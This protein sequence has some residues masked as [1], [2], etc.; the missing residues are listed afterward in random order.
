MLNA[1]AHAGG[2]YRGSWLLGRLPRWFW[3]VHEVAGGAFAAGVPNGLST[4]RATMTEPMALGL[5]AVQRANAS[6][7]DAP[8]V[9]G[10][11]PVGL[12]VIIA[13]KLKGIEPVVAADFSPRRRELAKAVGA[14][15]V[16]DPKN[17]SPFASW[18]EAAAV[19][20]PARAVRLSPWTPAPARRPALIFECV[21]VP[22]VIRYGRRA[23]ASANRGRRLMHG[24][25][26]DRTGQ[27][28]HEGTVYPVRARL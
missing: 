27:R 5:H 7:D 2:Q 24:A 26:S 3:R 8:L 11:G 16:L 22:G 21:G 10:C 4:E 17:A 1:R 23:A 25:R 6:R 28:S 12:A 9:I 18:S 19:K 13:L 20:A 15:I 14:D